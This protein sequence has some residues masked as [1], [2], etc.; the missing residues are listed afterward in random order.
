MWKWESGRVRSDTAMSAGLPMP[1]PTFGSNIGLVA[2]RAVGSAGASAYSL[3]IL[4]YCFFI[5]TKQSV[6]KLINTSL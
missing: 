4:I 6:S 2:G 5:R 3:D 1:S